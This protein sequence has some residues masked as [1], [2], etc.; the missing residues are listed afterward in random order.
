MPFKVEA[1]QLYSSVV[2]GL[3][4]HLTDS[5]SESLLNDIS[6]V[7]EGWVGGAG[8]PVAWKL[9]PHASP[10]LY[11][12][13]SSSHH[14]RG[15]F[16]TR[17]LFATPFEERERYP[18]GNYPLELNPKGIREWTAAVRAT[19]LHAP[20][21]IARV[22]SACVHFPPASSCVAVSP[23]VTPPAASLSNS[24]YFS[25]VLRICLVVA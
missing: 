15:Y 11:A 8:Q 7:V 12:N 17:H 6:E 1:S 23:T 24:K 21:S 10:P 19:S 2:K 13:P 3:P 18:A 25:C 5:A 14:Q 20:W 16:A 4:D 22:W 9:M